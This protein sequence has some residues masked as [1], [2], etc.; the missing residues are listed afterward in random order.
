MDEVYWATPVRKRLGEV[1]YAIVHRILHVPGKYYLWSGVA[2]GDR[3]TYE[4]DFMP[5]ELVADSLGVTVTMYPNEPMLGPGDAIIM[6][7]GSPDWD[8]RNRLHRIV[9]NHAYEFVGGNNA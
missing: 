8:E 3:F 9:I 5:V 7:F 2:Q 6:L 4:S 1:L